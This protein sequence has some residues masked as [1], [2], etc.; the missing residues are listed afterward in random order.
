[1]LKTLIVF[2]GYM[3][4]IQMVQASCGSLKYCDW[5]RWSSWNCTCCGNDVNVNKSL[6]VQSRGV[7]CFKNQTKEQCY[8]RCGLKL[9][10]DKRYGRCAELCPPSSQPSPCKPVVIPAYVY[11][12]DEDHFQ[13]DCSLIFVV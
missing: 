12:L 9:S 11:L 10:D 1:M 5:G 6:A 2:L 7:C 3:I 8:S 4:L 13:F